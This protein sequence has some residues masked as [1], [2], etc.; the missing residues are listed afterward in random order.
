MKRKPVHCIP[1]L[2]L[3]GSFP[4]SGIAAELAVA[5]GDSIQDSIDAAQPGDTVRV[6]PGVYKETLI[7]NKAVHLIGAGS[8]KTTLEVHPQFP[9]PLLGGRDVGITIDNVDEATI[10]GFTIRQAP[11]VIAG[12]NA[13]G[14]VSINGGSPL[15]RDNVIEG[16]S[17]YGLLINNH[18]TAFISGN[19][20]QDNHS[21]ANGTDDCNVWIRSATPFVINNLIQGGEYGCWIDGHDCDGMQF[22]N[23]TV[24]GHAEHGVHCDSSDPVLRNNIIVNNGIGIAAHHDWANPKLFYNN[25]WNENKPILGGDSLYDVFDSG[26]LTIDPGSI[27]ADP[28]FAH[29]PIRGAHLSEHSPCID[30]GAP[31]AIYNDFDGSR[32]DMGWT[33]GPSGVKPPTDTSQAGFLWTSVG[34]YP[35][36]D[37][38]QGATKRGLTKNGDRPFGGS[39][40]LF[41]AFGDSTGV[42]H[43]S[44]EIGRWAGVHGP[45][46]WEWTYIDDVLTKVRYD[47]TEG[48]VSAT[49]EAIGP[50]PDESG[51]PVYTVTRNGG[52]TFWAHENL[53]VVLNT[54]RHQ[55]GVYSIRITGYSFWD[56]EVS[57]P[58]VANL[59][60]NINNT[61][62]VVSIDSISLPGGAPFPECGIVRLGNPTQELEFDFTASHPDGFLDNYSFTALVGKNRAAGTI[63][64]ESYQESLGGSW[65]GRLDSESPLTIS[66]NPPTLSEWETC[67]YSFRLGAWARTTNGFGR[68]Y[69]ASAFE[70]HTLDL[71]GRSADLDGDGDVDAQDLAIFAAAYGTPQP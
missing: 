39:P 49:R 9:A 53:R 14:G 5:E 52:G 47:V 70:N 54:L 28:L 60:L 25:V 45:H 7:L 32:N 48:K 46:T 69:Y 8:A 21:A 41:G 59:V 61:K 10:S 67:A 50:F 35:V 68:L 1:A 57:V 62:P 71:E 66:P 64:H 29:V 37:L 3:L 23:N 15:L 24:G 16:F 33:G 42:T 26:F 36:S 22:Q 13:T 4:I 20:I 12:S 27:S 56:E 55:N 40:W 34:I 38:Y 17:D 51:I 19:I 6:G 65:A 11:L 31:Q 58:N 43:Y 18:S 44:I 30:A 63:A 2:I